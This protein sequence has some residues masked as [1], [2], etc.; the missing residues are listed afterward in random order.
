MAFVVFYTKIA[1]FITITLLFMGH[2]VQ[3]LFLNFE[4]HGKNSLLFIIQV[5]I[6]RSKSGMRGYK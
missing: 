5:S 3:V 6:I 1:F 2:P 4:L